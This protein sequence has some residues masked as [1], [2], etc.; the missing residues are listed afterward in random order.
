M[1]PQIRIFLESCWSA[2]E[3]ANCPVML[4]EEKIGLFAGGTSNVNW[5]VY[6]TLGQ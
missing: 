4:N 5:E 6:S 3:D 1:D 2:L